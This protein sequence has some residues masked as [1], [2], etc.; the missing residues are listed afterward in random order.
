MH[1]FHAKLLKREELFFISTCFWDKL[2]EPEY[3]VRSHIE[4]NQRQ[5]VV[6]HHGVMDFIKAIMRNI[7]PTGMYLKYKFIA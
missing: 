4:K 1:I 5:F 3:Q 2:C 6:A 7:E